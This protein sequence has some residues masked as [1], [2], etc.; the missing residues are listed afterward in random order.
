MHKRQERRKKYKC[1]Y[2]GSYPIVEV[3]YHLKA[4]GNKLIT[5]IVN[6]KEKKA[7]NVKKEILKTLTDTLLKKIHKLQI[8]LCENALSVLHVIRDIQLK[9]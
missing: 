2:K 5:H 9:Q 8:R 4:E 1:T 6:S 7:L 3:E